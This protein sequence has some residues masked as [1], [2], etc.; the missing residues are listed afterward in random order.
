[1]HNNLYLVRNKIFHL[2]Q[3]I[4][5]YN[6]HIASLRKQNV[7]FTCYVANFVDPSKSIHEALIK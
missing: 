5:N 3:N 4:Y 6:I 1:M 7:S 2:P